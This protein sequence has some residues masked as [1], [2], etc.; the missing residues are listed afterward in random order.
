M[1]HQR[2]YQIIFRPAERRM[3][4]NAGDSENLRASAKLKWKSREKA[5]C[6]HIKNAQVVFDLK[7]F[8]GLLC[9]RL[10]SVHFHI[11]V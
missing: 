8:V 11:F 4:G 3:S 10:L 5:A 1:K 9:A 7:G 6:F 2:Q